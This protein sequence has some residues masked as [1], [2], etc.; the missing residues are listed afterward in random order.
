MDFETARTKM[1]DNQIRTTDVTSHSILTAFLSVPREA[2]VSD[3]LKPLAYIDTDIEVLPAAAGQPARYIMEASPLAKLLQL[4]GV[5]KVLTMLRAELAHVM[6]L[7]GRPRVDLIDRTAVSRP[8]PL[9][10]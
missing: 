8:G 9:R 2:F 6:A 4:A 10:Y 7:I 5:T 1:V 3:R